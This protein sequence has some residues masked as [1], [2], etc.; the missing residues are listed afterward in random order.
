MAA[1]F[2]RTAENNFMK[3]TKLETVI[4]LSILAR[5]CLGAMIWMACK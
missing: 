3:G 4:L 5:L 1:P 2:A